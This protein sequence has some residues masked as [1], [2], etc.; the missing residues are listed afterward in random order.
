MGS[1]GQG[2]G[3]AQSLLLATREGGAGTDEPIL[4]L[5]PQPGADEAG[6]DQLGAVRLADFGAGEGQAGGHVVGDGHGRERVGLLED[7]AD[8]A[9]D[10]GQPMA[11]RVDVVAV[12]ADLAGQLCA[13]HRLVHP[14]QDA[15]EGRLATPRGPDERGHRCRGHRQR[16]VVEDLRVTEP[17]RDLDGVQWTLAPASGPTDDSRVR[18]P[19]A[20]PS[21][22]GSIT[23][24][25][26]PVMTSYAPAIP[27]IGPFSGVPPVGAEE[28]GVAGGEDPAVG[29]HLPVAVAVEVA[30]MPDDRLVERLAALE[31]K[32]PASPKVKIPPSDA[33]SQ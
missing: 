24:W 14:V 5:V 20:T 18:R 28:A 11:R 19:F 13:G 22:P 4:H 15:E 30:A 9:A 6:L 26:V 33:T 23:A 27:T 2:P 8:L 31:P 10:V 17:G 7:H 16:H 3:D 21:A 12:E 1:H 29:G 32:K 25:S